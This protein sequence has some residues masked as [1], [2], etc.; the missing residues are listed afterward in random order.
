MGAEI[1]A[2]NTPNV[3]VNKSTIISTKNLSLLYPNPKYLFGI[4][5]R[6]WAAKNKGFSHRVSIVRDKTDD[7]K[8]VIKTYLSNPSFKFNGSGE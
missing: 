6:I 2:E 5:I 1:L 3:H 7:L 4:G 8:C